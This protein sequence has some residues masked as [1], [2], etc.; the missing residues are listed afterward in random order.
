MQ[1]SAVCPAA[2][3]GTFK[4][5]KE[6]K[7]QLIGIF[8]YFSSEICKISS[9]R[10]TAL[11]IYYFPGVGQHSTEAPECPCYTAMTLFLG[12]Y[13]L[14]IYKC[15][16]LLSSICQSGYKLLVLSLLFCGCQRLLLPALNPPMIPPPRSTEDLGLLPGIQYKFCLRTLFQ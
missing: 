14:Y 10:S 5:C 9:R 8:N 4:H 15:I 16:Y 2:D 6:C 11:V 7:L 1:C 3:A 13:I 12:L